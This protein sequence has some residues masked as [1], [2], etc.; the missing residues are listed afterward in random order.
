MVRAKH[1][2]PVVHYGP[3]IAERTERVDVR[4]RLGVDGAVARV[5][6]DEP[7]H[8]RSRD[9]VVAVRQIGRFER[10]PEHGANLHAGGHG[11]AQYRDQC[12]IGVAVNQP[13]VDVAPPVRHIDE[14][15]GPRRFCEVGAHRAQRVFAADIRRSVGAGNAGAKSLVG[16]GGQKVAVQITQAGTAVARRCSQ[17]GAKMP[18]DRRRDVRLGF[19]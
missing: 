3:G 11:V 6:I 7:H 9:P 5:H 17:A 15:G 14:V 1:P 4:R 10:R 16:V 12:R 19:P 18:G 2:V 8:E 13:K